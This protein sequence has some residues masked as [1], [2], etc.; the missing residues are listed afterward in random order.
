MKKKD[1][2]GLWLAVVVM[3][4]GVVIEKRVYQGKT[5]NVA[6]DLAK[7]GAKDPSLTFT[8]FVNDNDPAFVNTVVPPD[9]TKFPSVQDQ[10]NALFTGGQAQIDMKKRVLGN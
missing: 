1:I 2:I 8:T 10:L 4:N 6:S 5:D 9:T 7:E 3:R